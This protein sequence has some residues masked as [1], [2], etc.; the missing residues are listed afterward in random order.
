MEPS[1]LSFMLIFM[2]LIHASIA[3]LI[4]QLM[5]L[6]LFVFTP[7]IPIVKQAPETVS[8]KKEVVT[9]SQWSALPFRNMFMAVPGMP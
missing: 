4:S 2:C 5:L 9:I 1:S 8:T 6:Y 3:P 7:D